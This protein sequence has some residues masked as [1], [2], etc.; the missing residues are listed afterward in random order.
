MRSRLSLAAILFAASLA[1]PGA[2]AAG[3][4]SS[5]PLPETMSQTQVGL[6]YF[7]ERLGLFGQWLKH[8]VWGDVWQPDAGPAFRPYFYGYW[9]NTKEYGWFWV[10]NEPYGDIVYHY[11]R[12]LFD[13]DYGW[14]WVPGYVWGPSWVIWRE[15][16]SDIGWLPM[17]PGYADFDQGTVQGTGIASYAADGWYGY[18]SFYGGDFVSNAFFDLWVFVGVQDFGRS[19]RRRYLTGREELRGR[20]THSRDKTS[21]RDDHDRMVDRSLDFDRLKRMAQRPF[22]PQPARRFMWRGVHATSVSEGREIFRRERGAGGEVSGFAK[23]NIGQ[24]TATDTGVFRRN[25]PELPV[26]RADPAAIAPG[27]RTGLNTTE[28]KNDAAKAAGAP[29]RRGMPRLGAR[30]FPG[31]AAT[32]ESGSRL[33]LGGPVP[34]EVSPGLAGI[35]VPNDVLRMG[36]RRGAFARRAGGNANVPQGAPVPIFE[37][38]PVGSGIASPSSTANRFRDSTMRIRGARTRL[39]DNY[40]HTDE[41]TRG[42]VNPLNSGLAPTPFP[43]GTPNAA[44][45][46][47]GTIRARMNQFEPVPMAPPPAPPIVTAAPAPSPQTSVARPGLPGGSENRGAVFRPRMPF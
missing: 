47:R 30:T 3:A 25:R 6:S 31:G 8:P 32:G 39:P 16:D 14:L 29:Y 38:G 22:E 37:S 1:M 9:E 12:W 24:P 27:S 15:G 44:S 28:S 10:S 33:P 26:G 43:S 34:A 2:V 40:P 11:G 18:Q 35:P 7:M 20:F 17:P 21:Y 4:E 45:F 5:R 42:M 13:P 19:D 23:P 46:P 36:A 41:K